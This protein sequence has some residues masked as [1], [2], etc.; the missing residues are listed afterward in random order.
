MR[1]VWAVVAFALAAVLIGAG[2]AQR[3]VFVGP[4]S[5]QAEIE[6]DDTMAYTVI[7]GDVFASLPGA[8]TL[9]ARG[10]GTVY[11]AYGRT[12]DMTAWLADVPFNAVS[13][14]GGDIVSEVI[15]PTPDEAADSG[16]GATSDGEAAAEPEYPTRDPAGSDLWLDEFSQEESLTTPLQVPADMSVLVAADGEQ[17]APSDLTVTWSIDN[18]TPWAGPLMVA[19]GVMLLVGLV[20]YL[21]AFRHHRRGRGPRR[22]GLPQAPVTEPI[23]VDSG[24]DG[25]D[26][27]VI[28]SSRS[29][30]SRALPRGKR[31]FAV[32]P[33]VAV[34]ALLFSGCSADAWPDLAGETAPTPTPTA[35][36]VPEGQQAPAVTE[37]QAESI[38]KRMAETV[39][40]ADES[41]DEDLA[42]TRLAGSALAERETNYDLRGEVDDVEPLPAIPGEPIAV[43]LPQAFDGWPRSVMAIVRDED[44]TT[45]APT[46]MMLSQED[47][48]SNYKLTYTARMEASAELPGLAPAWLGATQVPPDSSFLILP[49]D[50]LSA[51]YADVLDEGDE[52]EYAALFDAET[53]Q[54]RASVDEDRDRRLESLNETGEDTAKMSFAAG[55]GDHDPLALA[56]IESGAI[57]AVELFET[58]TVEPTDDRAVIKLEDNTTVKALTGESQSDGGFSTTFSDQLF[59]YVPGQGSDEKIQLLGYGSNILSAKVIE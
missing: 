51:A 12:A 3:T 52:S 48:W 46:M 24:A 41:R 23:D 27:G 22:K 37:T 6:V 42:A 33:V 16:D 11:T 57:V 4:D 55:P 19:G 9:V 59:F 1:F 5:A 10:E 14:D 32:V 43:L 31:S 35:T 20:L 49:P 2:I 53:D 25:A 13:I 38:V 8:Q 47:P 34:S 58:D 15:V 45:V 44:D 40:E 28:S 21:L 17:P 39:A 36:V 26:K 50:Q 54:F 30:R 29:S 56:T 7:D 18:S